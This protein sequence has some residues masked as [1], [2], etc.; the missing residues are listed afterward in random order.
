[1]ICVFQ[2]LIDNAVATYSFGHTSDHFAIA[3][4]AGVGLYIAVVFGATVSGN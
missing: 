2:V 4:T 3:T 1:M